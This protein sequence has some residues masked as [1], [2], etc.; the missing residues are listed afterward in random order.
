MAP[1][2][3]TLASKEELKRELDLLSDQA[4]GVLYW[5]QGYLGRHPLQSLQDYT[6]IPQVDWVIW[7]HLGRFAVPPDLTSYFRLPANLAECKQEGWSLSVKRKATLIRL[8]D[9]R[10]ASFQPGEGDGWMKL[11]HPKYIGEYTYVHNTT[12][13]F[14]DFPPSGFNLPV[15]WV[16]DFSGTSGSAVFQDL[17]KTRIQCSPPLLSDAIDDHSIMHHRHWK[18]WYAKYA[19]QKKKELWELE[20]NCVKADHAV[21]LGSL[22]R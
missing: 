21:K 15:G 2:D 12:G 20:M 10:D 9:E 17:D 16:R 7:Y 14:Q 6:H 11:P 13:V 4:R 18:D 22:R 5:Q 3:I 8:I 1:V 19:R